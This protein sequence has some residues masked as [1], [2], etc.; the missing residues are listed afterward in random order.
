MAEDRHEVKQQ[1]TT[2]KKLSSLSKRQLM[3]VSDT[4]QSDS[5]SSDPEQYIPSLNSKFNSKLTKELGN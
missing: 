3:V 2:R 4:S 1:D 5:D